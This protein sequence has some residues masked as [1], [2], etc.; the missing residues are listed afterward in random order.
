MK[1]SLKESFM[2]R[3]FT[4]LEL[5]IVV[6]IISILAGIAVPNYMRTTEKAKMRDAEGKL[7]LIYQAQRIY[8]LDNGI[9]ATKDQLIPNYIP[10]PDSND[11]TFSDAAAT[12]ATTFSVAA[13]RQNSGKYDGQT[14]TVDQTGTLTYSSNYSGGIPN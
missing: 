12:T 11:W 4:L 1:P 13:T 10:N 2:K 3:A 8:Q 9:Y 14:I 7:N 6:V 5:L